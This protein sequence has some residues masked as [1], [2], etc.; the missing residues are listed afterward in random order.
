MRNSWVS[1]RQGLGSAAAGEVLANMWPCVCISMTRMRE[2]S[3]RALPGS[4]RQTGFRMN[5]MIEIARTEL[6]CTFTCAV[7]TMCPLK[8]TCIVALRTSVGHRRVIHIEFAAGSF[9][10]D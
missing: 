8:F 7:G 3:V 9:L 6:I 5:L 10:T 4:H 1:K 2:W